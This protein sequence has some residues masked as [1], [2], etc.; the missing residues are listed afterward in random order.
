MT[1]E[2]RIKLLI[3]DDHPV[4]RAG[5]T[6]ML[7]TKSQ[8]EVLGSAANGEEAL[9][10]I[11]SR[12]VDVVLLD[13][14]MPKMDGFELLGLIVQR[15]DPPRVLILTSFERDEDIY[16]AVQAGAHGY[17]TKDA[18]ESEM[19]E[20]IETVYKSKRYI[21]SHLAMRL[22]ERLM[23]SNLTAR[24][25]ETLELLAKGL[26][27]KQIGLALA[28]SENTV[29]NHVNSLLVKL[30]VSDRTEAA[31]LAMQQGIL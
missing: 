30:N 2:I 26:T 27:N 28:I 14:R 21:P 20:A 8:L 13:L 1:D 4:V 9:K 11:K 5:L 15:Q 25:M 19:V 12:V 18:T 6:S 3:V 31:T 10:I 29:R 23:R 7:S 16:R 17:I 24:E 22:A